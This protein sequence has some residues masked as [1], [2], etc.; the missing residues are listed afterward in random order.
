MD[1]V[2]LAMFDSERAALDARSR[3]LSAGF[4]EDAVAMA[5]D[6]E[7]SRLATGSAEP[8]REGAV[9]RFLRSLFG[10]RREPHPDD[11]DEAYREAFRRGASGVT[12]RVRS[13]AEL[14]RAEQVLNVAG[15]FDV[16]ERS[17]QW[18]REGWA[19]GGRGAVAGRAADAQTLPVLEEELEVGKRTVSRG[20]VRVFSHVVEEPAG[21]T[22]LL[23][24]ERVRVDRHAADRPA[25]EAEFAAFQE[26]VLEIREMVEE[27]V[28]SKTARV[29]EEVEVRKQIIERN[30]V[31]RDT[32]R[33]TQVD[34][35]RVEPASRGSEPK[36]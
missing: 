12:V 16:D 32:L 10:P 29:V 17:R 7:P 31:V 3:L 23:R 35:G 33:R 36:P 26:G 34:V 13:E 11:A 6:G 14:E 2:L 15:A 4:A 5:G 21:E 18:Q 30:E 28:V 27:A 9:T 22:V 25:T 1:S 19:G 24:E 20:A 8:E